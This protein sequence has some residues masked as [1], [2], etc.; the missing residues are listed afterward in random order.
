MMIR[1]SVLCFYLRIFPQETFR[2]IVY[3]VIVVNILYSTAFIFVSIFQCIPVRAAWGRWDGT[4]QAACVNVNVLGWASGVINIFLDVVVL[5][6]P[7]PRLAKLVMSWERKAHLLIMFGL[8]IL[9]VPQLRMGLYTN[10]DT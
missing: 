1:L 10:T 3:A 9:Y 5:V 6:V 8:G 4:L 2:R 7:L